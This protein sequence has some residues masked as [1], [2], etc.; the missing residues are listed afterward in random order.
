MSQE[1][2]ELVWK[3][4]S[5]FSRGDLEDFLSGWHPD[6]E[7]SAAI[8][9]D[10]EG[11]SGTFR[12]HDGLRRWFRELHDLY[13]DLNTEILEVQDRG[14]RLVVVFVIRGRGSNSGI[15]NENT[16]A[17]VVAVRQGKVSET[18]DYRSRAE[19]LQAV[20]LSE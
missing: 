18:R 1:N 2:V 4:H 12:G 11:E 13:D 16:L 8:Q 20:G 19:A 7:Y 3:L 6:A 15:V 9:Q 17:Q 10:V 5:A 14:G